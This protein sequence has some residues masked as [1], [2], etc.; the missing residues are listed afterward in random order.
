MKLINTIP[1]K[2]TKFKFVSNHYDLHLHGTCTYK[3]ELCEFRTVVGDPIESDDENDFGFEPDFCRIYK[4]TLRQKIHWLLRQF[5][6]EAMVGYHYSYRNGKRGKH[7]HYRK[8]KWVYV[9]LFKM[10]YK[11]R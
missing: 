10:F 2:E 6:F 1:Y 3:G 4:L 9:L 5:K 8:P 11:V 7:F